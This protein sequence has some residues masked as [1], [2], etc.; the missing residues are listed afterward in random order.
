MASTSVT[1][2]SK[3]T[4]GELLTMM[5]SFSAS[6]TQTKGSPN[7]STRTEGSRTRGVDP[8]IMLGTGNGK[9]D[10]PK[11][12][13]LVMTLS[14]WA[15]SAWVR[16]IERHTSPFHMRR[17]ARRQSSTVP[18]AG[19]SMVHVLAGACKVGQR[20]S[21][22]SLL[23][24]RP[25]SSTQLLGFRLLGQC[26]RGSVAA[27]LASRKRCHGA[28]CCALGLYLSSAVCSFQF[29]SFSILYVC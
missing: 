3:S 26:D 7:S 6:P 15:A 22:R 24:E 13:F 21:V 16:L 27:I 12:F 8:V 17:R 1:S 25:K 28:T 19:T 10:R 4:S 23:R 5:E 20:A 29:S 11:A 14:R 18:M 2:S 9:P